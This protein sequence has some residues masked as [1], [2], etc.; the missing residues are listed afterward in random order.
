MVMKSLLIGAGISSIAILLFILLFYLLDLNQAEPAQPI[1]FSHKTHAG[2]NQIPCL[3]CHQY[4]R[5]AAVAGIPSVEKCRSCHMVVDPD[6][7][8]VKKILNYWDKKES[9]SWIKVIDLPDHVYFTHKRHIRSGIDCFI[10][11]GAVEQM[12][13]L[14]QPLKFKMGMCLGCHRQRKASIDCWTCHK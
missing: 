12:E 10:C 11:H 2:M 7:P 4:A 1:A 13:R 8:E 14:Y 6:H 3:Y 9:I 5:K